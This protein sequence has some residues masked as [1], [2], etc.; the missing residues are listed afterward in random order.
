MKFLA[1]RGVYMKMD[2]ASQLRRET[3]GFFT[4]IHPKATWRANLQ[5][6]NNKDLA[7]KYE[8]PGDRNGPENK[9]RKGKKG[10]FCSIEC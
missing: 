10:K 7:L 4:H 6:T 5:E 9:G 1:R 2:L 8:R 3:V